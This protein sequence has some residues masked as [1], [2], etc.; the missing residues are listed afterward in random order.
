[1]YSIT[2]YPFL[3][4]DRWREIIGFHPWHFWQLV[5]SQNA[6]VTSACNTIVYQHSWQ[7][8]DKTGRQDI[9]EALAQAESRIKERLY[10]WPYPHYSENTFE[11]PKYPDRRVQRLGYAGGDGHWAS[12]DLKERHVQKIGVETFSLLEDEAAVVYTDLDGDTLK[13]TFTVTIPAPAGLT[14]LSQVRLYFNSTDRYTGEGIGPRWEIKPIFCALTGGNL[15]IKG[16]AWTAIRPVLYEKTRPGDLQISESS[17]FASTVDVYRRYIDPTGI[18]VD[19]AQGKLIWETLPYWYGACCD[20][21]NNTT[22]PAAL[23]YA[24]AR[25]GIRNSE[26]GL[27]TPAQAVWNSVTG[28]WCT[29]DYQYYCNMPQRV[30]LRYEAGYPLVNGRMA[31]KMEKAVSYLAAAELVKPICACETANRILYYW[32]RDMSIAGGEESY[33][34][35]PEDLANPFGT[36]RG[37]IFAW[38]EV[39]ELRILNGFSPSVI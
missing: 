35:S 14:D 29:P 20:P 5:D 30:T 28:V 24:I 6:P 25:A 18:T 8:T 13:E 21:V 38:K 23:G 17:N 1:M 39:K 37:H 12:L 26:Q 36:R 11:L 4:L 15:V 10:F 34:I 31:E 27:V 7:A 19:T 33:G 3:S 32:Q 9:Y 16:R 2:N 22:D